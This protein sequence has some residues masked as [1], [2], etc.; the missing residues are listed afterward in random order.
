MGRKYYLPLFLL[1]LTG[2]GAFA[3]TGEIRGKITEEGGKE[4]IPFASVAVLLN[5]NQV[6]AGQTDFDGNYSIKQL[7]PGT[8]EVKATSVGYSTVSKTGVLV[9]V[10]KFT[11]IDFTLKKGVTLGEVKIK[12]ER[13]IIDIGETQTAQTIDIV[14]IKQAPTRSVNSVAS[15]KAGIYQKKEG[16]ALNIRGE[17]SG[18]TVYYV[19]GQKQI[20]NP[21]LSQSGIEQITVITGGLSAQ[22]GDVSGGVINI[23]TRG[24]SS[25]FGG[26]IEAATSKYLD[27]YGF[28][29]LGLNLTGPIYRAKDAEGKKGRSIA[30]FFVAAEYQ[31][32]KD[33]DP[34]SIPI[35]KVKNNIL[36]DVRLH[37]LVQSPTAQNYIHRSSFF[38]FDSLEQQKYRENVAAD[39]YRLN[40]KIDFR[41][42][43]TFTVTLGGSGEYTKAH[44]YQDVYSLMNYDNNNEVIHENYRAFARIT[45]RL[46]TDSKE[47]T[48]SSIKNASYTIQVDYLKNHR[49]DQN[50]IHKDNV[51]DYGYVGKF[52][53]YAVPNYSF[54]VITRP[55]LP[56]S[57][58]LTQVGNQDTSYTFEAGSQNPNTANYTSQYYELTEDF[59]TF[60]YQDTRDN[61]IGLGALGNGDN[62]IGQNVYGLWATPG[63][64]RTGYDIDDK[65]QYRFTASFSADIK[66]H[67]IIVGLE[68]EQ[69]IDKGY[70]LRPNSLWDLMRLLGNQQNKMPGIDP[71]SAVIN[72]FYNGNA[73][74]TFINYT[75]ALYTPFLDDDGNITRGFYENARE[76][77]GLSLNDTL[78][79]DAYDPSQYSLDMFTPDEL[80]NSGNSIVSYYGYD[81]MGNEESKS[82]DL[83]NFY[84]D[85]DGNNNFTRKVDAFRPNYSSLYLLDKFTYND[86][87]FNIGVRVDRFD[88]NQQVLKDPYVLYETHKAGDA[89]TEALT[90]VPDNI[91]DD[92]VVYVNNSETPTQVVGYR[93]ESQWYDAAGNPTT[94]VSSLTGGVGGTGSI[95]PF[96]TNYTDYKNNKV[97]VNA[98]KDYDPQITVM[99]RIAFSFPISDEAYF[100]A[101]YDVLSQ[102]PDNP[103]LIRFNPIT[104]YSWAQGNGGTFSNPNLK[105]RRT[106][107]YEINFQQKLS[108][109]SAFTI[110]AFYKEIQ[111]EIQII[112]LDFA[113]PIKYSAYGNQDFGTVKG[114]TFSYDLRR[115]Q[116]V[117]MGMSY[118]LQFAAGTGSDANTNSGI[119][120][121]AG[122]T[123][124]REIKPLDFDQRHTFVTSLDF[125]YGKGTEYNG[126]VWFNKQVFANA[127]INLVF[128]AGSGTPYTRKSNITPEADFTTT[129]NSRSVI[130]GSI[131]GSRLPWSYRLD[132]KVDKAFSLVTR[133][134]AEG[135]SEKALALNVYLQVQ[136]VLNTKNIDVVYRATGSPDDDGYI[137]SPTAQAFISSQVSPQAYIDMYRVA[138]NKPANYN[139]PRTIHLGVQVNF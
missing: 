49:V 117:R 50:D 64:V 138:V 41:P 53:S 3:Q 46:G 85:K 132:A 34:T 130:S 8:Y 55:N 107:D 27:P 25:Q 133:K 103:D 38:T 37:P 93:L 84:N 106:T 6:Q 135:I 47:K 69:R 17:R 120:S 40:A 13:P 100:S 62:R 11:P 98:F 15:Q 114:L 36:E 4:G 33:P 115:S 70:T 32:D 74:F 108:R 59:G 131:N 112:N 123:N 79:T 48:S 80:F 24:P 61:V 128:R 68:Y 29:L 92:A 67:N 136:N 73:P 97:N 21:N 60:G 96:L 14:D 94:D 22:Y 63:R 102:R 72:T 65:S 16:G 42:I 118:T 89:E 83:K 45:Q 78:Q 23:T 5:G 113:F 104:Y 39:A 137:E 71:N 129:A 116:N 18:G 95:Q 127:G 12:W 122:Q 82:Y 58:I 87:I 77:F 109:T 52:K 90:N 124:L 86:I 19:D 75:E 56:D 43:E 28:G 126:P 76:K 26:G 105:P 44:E 10:D 66:K 54:S 57:T 9:S 88:A 134:A 2:F 81:Y 31:H 1:L 125:H 20:G 91:E 30:G 119:L 139:L 110:S 121:Q 99:P 7:T 101:H 111:D 35:Y 51:F